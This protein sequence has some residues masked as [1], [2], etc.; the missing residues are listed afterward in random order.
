MKPDVKAY[1]AKYRPLR[2]I[3]AVIDFAGS[4]CYNFWGKK[5]FRAE[6][7]HMEQVREYK[8]PSCG[9]P[10]EFDIRE[11]CMVCRYCTSR[12]DLKYIRSHFNEVTDK[13]LSDFDWVERTKY[14]WEPYVLK[15]LT[16]FSCP[17]CGGNIIT[18]GTNASAKCP[19]C[20]H[21]V[22]ISSNFRGD[23]RPD[24]VI[25]FRLSSEEFAEK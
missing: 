3:A 11:Q 13:K 9:A 14:V 15:K 22:V 24:K 19:F 23:I 6:V 7:H 1:L 17:S 20:S 16:E 8:C 12:Y 10:L 18:S 25:P 21:D 4:L 5:C 2:K